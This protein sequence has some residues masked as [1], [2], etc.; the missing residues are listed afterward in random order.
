MEDKNNLKDKLFPKDIMPFR[1]SPA[2]MY[3]CSDGLKDESLMKGLV[4]MATEGEGGVH[5][6]YYTMD[7][8]KEFVNSPMDNILFQKI[9]R[10]MHLVTHSKNLP[11][12]IFRTYPIH[13]DLAKVEFREFLLHN[14]NS[15][16]NSIDCESKTNYQIECSNFGRIR[17]NGSIT[18]PIEEKIG[19]LEIHLDK[20]K[21][22]VYRI[23]AETW[24]V[25]PSNDSSGWHVHHISNDGYD[26]TPGN[27]LWINGG[28]HIKKISTPREQKIN[29]KFDENADEIKR[30]IDEL[31]S[32]K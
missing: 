7:E 16:S 17:I 10:Y 4:K 32:Q 31:N 21:Y 15:G 1:P 12:E 8:L 13:I 24:C 18:K 5:V 6:V 26:N 3:F 22:P 29:I 11:G 25:C 20:I 28:V 9:R 27:L 19:W 23:V 2:D 14:N 30:I